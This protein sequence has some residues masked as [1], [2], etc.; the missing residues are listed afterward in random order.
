M[1]RVGADHLSR[2][3]HAN[4]YAVVGKLAPH[5]HDE[6]GPFERTTDEGLQH[7]LCC[8]ARHTYKIFFSQEFLLT[9]RRPATAFDSLSHALGFASATP[10]P[11]S[12]I[13]V[14]L[15]FAVMLWNTRSRRIPRSSARRLSKRP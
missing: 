9:L 2:V 3:G 15:W 6:R 10:G 1:K 5:R 12:E 11:R 4:R 7:F 8:L 13:Q 14:C